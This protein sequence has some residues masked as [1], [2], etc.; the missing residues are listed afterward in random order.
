[1]VCK[2]LF[3]NYFWEQLYFLEQKKHV[4]Q[5]LFLIFVIK[6]KNGVFKEYHLVIFNSIHLFF[7]DYFKK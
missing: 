2:I 7:Y 6:K 1:M 3:D 5:P 4:W